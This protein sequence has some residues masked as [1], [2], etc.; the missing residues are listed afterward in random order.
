MPGEGTDVAQPRLPPPDPVEPP[1]HPH[2]SGSDGAAP[3]AGFA[4]ALPAGRHC[5]YARMWIGTKHTWG[6]SLQSSEKTALQS[7]LNTR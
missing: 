5:T 6:H 4:G 3:P 7:M 2:G 1:E